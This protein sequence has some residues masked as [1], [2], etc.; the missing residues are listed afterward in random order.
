MNIK[1]A[2]IFVFSS[3]IFSCKGDDNVSCVS[4]SNAQTLDFIVCNEANGNASVNGQDTGQDYD[5]YISNLQQQE[6]TI[7]N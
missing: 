1:L 2:A 5:V 4:C 6:E 7:C 3:L